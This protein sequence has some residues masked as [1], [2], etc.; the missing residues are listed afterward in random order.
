MKSCL[1]VVPNYEMRLR[2]FYRYGTISATVIEKS[3]ILYIKVTG[4]L[5]VF[6]AQAQKMNASCIMQPCS[7]GVL[8]CTKIGQ[9]PFKQIR[10][11]VGHRN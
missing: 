5:L 2:S 6:V 10:R 11:N 1:P 9:E 8:I 3:R 4:A 7:I